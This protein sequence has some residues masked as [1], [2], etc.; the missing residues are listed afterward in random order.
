MKTPLRLLSV[1]CFSA[2]LAACASSPSNSLGQ[3][4][5]TQ[6]TDLDTLL[7]QASKRDDSRGIGL[8]LAAADLAWQQRLVARARKILD[9][10]DLN[11]ATPA[12]LIFAKTLEAE[13]AV[14]LKQPKS[15]LKAL[16][17]PSFQYLQKM[18]NNQQIRTGLVRA[19][20]FEES[21]QFAAAVRERIKIAPILTESAAF[22]NHQAT[23]RLVNTLSITQLQLELESTDDPIFHGWLTL[24]H[25]TKSTHSLQQQQS[26]LLQWVLQNPKH[27]AGQKLPEALQQLQQ[28]QIQTINSIALLLPSNDPNQ[29]VVN[30][31]R[32]G[33][34]AAHYIAKENGE[35]T[36]NIRLYDSN[37][38]T[39][40]DAF[41]QQAQSDGIELVVGPWEKD[42]VR[43]LASRPTLAIATLALNYADRGQIPPQQLFQYGL[44]A[45]DEARAAANR[46]WADGL[47]RTAIMVPAS[48][49]G[50]R[51][52]AEFA[53]HWKSLGGQ[54]VGTTRF[55][56]PTEL[57]AQIAELLELRASEQRTKQLEATL[58]M[59]VA[60]QPARRQD[61]EFIFLAASPEQARH[62]KPAL[63][64]Q[65]AGDI[66]IYATSA[67]HS[68]ANEI[69]PELNGLQFS[70][71]PWFIE[72]NHPTR[73]HITQ[74]WSN[75][76]GGLGRFYAM[77]ADA[78]RITSQLQQLS[79]LPS[80]SSTGLT[81]ILQL[82]QQRRIHRNLYWV[83]FNNGQLTPL[84]DARIE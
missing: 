24:A 60:A 44:A 81:G 22:D 21:S 46:A 7:Q 40:L 14:A 52:Q 13:I 5:P 71:M 56:R 34:F 35:P 67:V 38:F 50:E 76:Q 26:D 73:Q 37:S 9:G 15:A 8:Y 6:Y 4:P 75:A 20:A 27:P 45:E 48:A 41:Y 54:V 1:I 72:P 68:G 18:P 82:D 28:L 16:N 57:P 51:I 58:E 74:L 36:P 80:N 2:F 39:S 17:H 65:Y 79:T 61:I 49:W 64:F 78:Y 84:K 12:Q 10:I 69:Y 55:S 83:E 53:A 59:K 63:A 23:W 25:V 32:N 43:Q 70:E 3:L 30:A 62:I 42:L 66:P 31:L 77:G 33:F 47:R 11:Q 19:Q 29:N